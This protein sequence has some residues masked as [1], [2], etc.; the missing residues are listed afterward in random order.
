[1]EIPIPSLNGTGW[2]LYLSCQQYGKTAVHGLCEYLCTFH[3]KYAFCENNNKIAALH[4]KFY[5][6]ILV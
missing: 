4:I 6:A 5:G 2:G 3:K 1:M